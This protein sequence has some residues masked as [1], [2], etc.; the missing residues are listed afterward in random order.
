MTMSK[1][2]AVLRKG[3]GGIGCNCRVRGIGG[4]GATAV[5]A[6]DGAVSGSMSVMRTR[7]SCTGGRAPRPFTSPTVVCATRQ[8]PS[9]SVRRDA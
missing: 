5:S 2:C 4:G 8:L 6:A 1:A 9:G 3:E 7:G